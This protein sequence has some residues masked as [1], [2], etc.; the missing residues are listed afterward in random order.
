[1]FGTDW[2]GNE[3]DAMRWPEQP[4]VV[5]QNCIETELRAARAARFSYVPMSQ[6]L[7]ERS[8][9]KQQ[10][11]DEFEAAKTCN[12]VALE[13]MQDEAPKYVL[14]E[15]ADWEDNNARLLRL[16]AAAEWL[17]QRCRDGVIEGFH[18]YKG[19]AAVFPLPSHYWNCE[20]EFSG[21]L[22]NGG[23][24]VLLETRLDMVDSHF[25][26]SRVSLQEATASLAHSP[27]FVD[28]DDLSR[29]APD[30]K[31]AVRVALNAKLFSPE[32]MSGGNI[33]R[34]IVAA[35]D[36]EN[37]TIAKSKIIQMTAT[38][39]WPRSPIKKN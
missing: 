2:I 18:Q 12:I 34:A 13:K 35:A 37:R 3:F 20:N 32:V 6:T 31:L 10:T 14:A 23:R 16:T 30:L 26:V 7:G 36:S 38:M 1:M 11:R 17:G 8:N 19:T 24:P 15:Q 29:L 33:E 21:W 27:L 4:L 25:F 22:T 9:T 5:Y 28:R 39:R